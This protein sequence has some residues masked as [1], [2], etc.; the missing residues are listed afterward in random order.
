M[1]PSHALS[2]GWRAFQRGG[3]WYVSFRWTKGV[4]PIVR[5]AGDSQDEAVHL[6]SEIKR[7]RNQ[8]VPLRD[9]M[10]EFFGEGVSPTIAL[11]DAIPL[12]LA[13]SEKEKRKTAKTRDGERHRLLRVAKLPWA[14]RP[15]TEVDHEDIERWLLGF[16][17]EGRTGATLNRWKTAVSAVYRWAHRKRFLPRTVNPTL[18]I[19][20]F[21][22]SSG[23]EVFLTPGE[24]EAWIE[25]APARFSIMARFYARTGVRRDEAR[26]LRW[27]SVDLSRGTV[28]VEAELS[29][30]HKARELPLTP[31]LVDALRALRSRTALERGRMPGPEDYVFA[32]EDEPWSMSRVRSAFAKTV[33]AAGDAIEASKRVVLRLH[34]IR[35]TVGAILA[36]SGVPERIIAQFL[37]HKS[38]V[39]TRRYA[40]LYPEMVGQ[41]T[42]AL[43][44][45]ITPSQPDRLAEKA[46]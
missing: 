25:S 24:L 45:A 7:C 13:E 29:K 5:S 43:V 9:V 44:K 38:L 12:Y 36:S 33:E 35:H 46:G 39:T 18:E 31:D 17:A 42:A 15:M 2:P 8:S 32:I 37:G 21:T 23:R 20:R 30:N 28:R 34:D 40:H 10:A 16:R 3:R 6:L 11:K 19:E 1:S 14:S 22:E 41:A 26:L 27:R 4:A